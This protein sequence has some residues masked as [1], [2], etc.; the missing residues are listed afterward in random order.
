ML[1]CLA[2]AACLWA[3]APKAEEDTNARTTIVQ[4]VRVDLLSLQVTKLPRDD[5]GSGIKPGTYEK[6]PF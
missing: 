3:Q 5:L 6:V 2:C 1:P 4:P